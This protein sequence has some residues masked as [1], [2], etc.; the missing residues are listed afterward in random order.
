MAASA[1]LGS[2]VISGQAMANTQICSFNNNYV[3][4]AGKTGNCKSPGYIYVRGGDKYSITAYVGENLTELFGE[5]DPHE[6]ISSKMVGIV[7]A[8]NPSNNIVYTRKFTAH[9]LKFPLISFPIKFLT[10]QLTGYVAEDNAYYE[11]F[12]AKKTQ[13]LKISFTLNNVT[14]TKLKTTYDTN[15][16]A[17]IANGQ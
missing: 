8:Y 13:F 14:N 2:G 16:F 6:D 10:I 9:D 4:A 17:S 1:L 15:A 5:S 11:V 7:T 3:L 12:T